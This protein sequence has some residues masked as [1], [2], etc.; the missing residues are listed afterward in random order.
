MTDKKRVSVYL[1]ECDYEHLKRLAKE[2]RCSM[3]HLLE[4]FYYFWCNY[5]SFPD[6]KMDLK[7][8]FWFH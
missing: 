7:W 6:M 4:S 2:N 3:S 1:D 5:D 8:R